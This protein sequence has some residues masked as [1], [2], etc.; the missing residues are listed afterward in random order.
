MCACGAGNLARRAGTPADAWAGAKVEAPGVGTIA[1]A[2][3]RIARATGCYSS[4]SSELPGGGA[5]DDTL[6]FSMA[7]FPRSIVRH[8]SLQNGKSG[9]PSV[10]SFLQIGQRIIPA[11]M[12]RC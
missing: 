1:D 2:A 7:Q 8:R 9:V 4:S 3:G 10:T 6:Y 5:G 12:R 11:L